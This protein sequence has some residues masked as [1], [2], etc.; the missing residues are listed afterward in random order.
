M[1]FFVLTFHTNFFR[2]NAKI[3]SLNV[4]GA[5]PD[6]GQERPSMASSQNI[7]DNNYVSL[8]DAMFETNPLE[9]DCDQ[10]V[11]VASRPIEI[12][13]DAVRKINSLCL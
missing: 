4:L 1:T 3:D 5:A 12:I 8:L 6:D 13:Y 10:R 9:G 7:Q 11:R 2:V